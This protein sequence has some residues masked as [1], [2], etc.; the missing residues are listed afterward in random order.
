MGNTWN[1]LQ[2]NFELVLEVGQVALDMWVWI[3]LLGG[4]LRPR[5]HQEERITLR[6]QT[7]LCLPS[8]WHCLNI[9]TKGNPTAPEAWNQAR[10]ASEGKRG[11]AVCSLTEVSVT[12]LTYWHSPSDGI[13]PYSSWLLQGKTDLLYPEKETNRSILS[14]KSLSF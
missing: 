11:V 4:A 8:L 5:M 10:D 12:L 7:W 6:R 14:N 2:D 3:W 1:P 9:K 13:V